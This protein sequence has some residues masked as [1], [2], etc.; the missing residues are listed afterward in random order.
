MGCKNSK[1][2]KP[3][4]ML[5]IQENDDDTMSPF[6]Y[7]RGSRDAR[8]RSQQV[9]LIYTNKNIWQIHVRIKLLSKYEQI[10]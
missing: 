8:A 4:T 3:K 9:R 2:P 1:I 7:L 5:F 10:F 6:P